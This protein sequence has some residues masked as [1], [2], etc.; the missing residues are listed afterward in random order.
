MQLLKTGRDIVRKIQKLNPHRRVSQLFILIGITLAYI[1]IFWLLIDQAGPIISVFLSMPVIIAGLYFGQIAGLLASLIGFA[2]NIYLLIAIGGYPLSQISRDWPGYLA[3]LVTGYIAGYLHDETIARKRSNDEIYSRERFITLISIATKSITG[4]SNPEEAYYRLISHLTNLFTA[5]YAYLIYWDETNQQAFLMA[6]T[7]SLESTTYPMPLETGEAKIIETVLQSGHSMF[8]EDVQKS[9]YIVNPSPFRKLSLQTKSAL[10]IPLSTKDYCFGAVILVFDSPRR[11]TPEEITY[12]ELASSQITLALRTVQQQLE[13]ETQLKEAK[14]LA[15]IERA[16]SESER[17]GVDKVLQLIVDSAIELIPKAD[18]VILHLTDDEKQILVPR[19]VAGY[20]GKDKRKLNMRL[21]E[22][23]AGQ[24]IATG[25]VITIADVYSDP[26]FLKR[27][28]PVKFR[29][30]VVAPIRS[31]NECIGTIS[32]HSDVANAFSLEEV[33]LLETLGTQVAIGIDNANLLETTRQNLKEINILY[34]ISQVLAAPLDA[35]QVMKNVADLLQQTFGYQHVIIYVVDPKSGDL[36]VRQGS[37]KAAPRL[38]KQ[39]YRLSVGEGIVG[40]VANTGEPFVTNNVENV[41]FYSS[42]PLLPDIKS[43]MTVPIVIENQVIGVLD[44]QQTSS[45]PDNERQLN[46]LSAV[47][48][49]LAVALNRID[50]LDSLEQ[51]VQ[52]RTRDLVVLYNLITII[53]ENWRLQDLLEL[54]LVLTLETVKAD[55]GIIYLADGREPPGLKPII[56]RGFVDGFQI[57][58][59]SLPD[60]ELARRVSKQHKPLALENLADIPAFAKFNGMNSYVGIPIMVRGDMRGV[61]S[62]FA[63]EK[64]VFGSDEMALLT[65]I[66]DHLGIGI[67]NSILF[68][69]SRESAA[70][71]ERNRL[72]RNLHDSVSQL[73]Y[74]LTLMAGSTKKMLER[75]HDLD[76]VKTSVSRLGDTAHQALKEMRL[77][78]YELRPAVLDS[79]GLVSV[80]QHRIDTVE[81]RLGVK[82]DLQA[83]EL[84]E[85]PSEMEDALYHIALEALNNIV[86]HAKSTTASIKF[87]SEKGNIVMQISDDGSGF[88]AN[89]SHKGQGLRNMRERVQMLGGELVVDSKPGEGTRVT[90]QVKIPPGSLITS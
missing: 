43:V 19:A 14:A 25:K 90:V 15:N 65:S 5:D 6:A 48:D 20:T 53:S 58:V 85:L 79:E 77:L 42:H 37:G 32:I 52:Q 69:Q 34:R 81:E 49:Q 9:T 10:V 87:A 41:A 22:G 44:I 36:I 45:T 68:E 46:L 84:P 62:L 71:E 40:H 86:K 70:L 83:K 73:L 59:G 8:I 24:V 21:G 51:R 13:I 12:V 55:R 1:V 75:D 39:G 26:R 74:S 63:N 80:L 3:I 38:I 64:G 54:S 60:D 18:N 33:S 30:L 76:S 61:F 78:L 7:K 35:D 16:L 11:F 57:E 82:V 29:S 28:I 27:T 4:I 47:A 50:I 56:Q 89:Q 31:H 66:A 2:L 23:I 17:V 72:A 88:D 67:E